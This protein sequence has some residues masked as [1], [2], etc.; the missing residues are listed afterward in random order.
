MAVQRLVNRDGLAT[1]RDPQPGDF[2]A[3]VGF[4]VDPH[5]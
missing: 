2:K 3:N 1:D 5:R 4:S